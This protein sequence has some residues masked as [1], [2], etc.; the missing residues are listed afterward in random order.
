MI[1]F[2]LTAEITEKIFN[3]IMIFFASFASLR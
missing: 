1:E 3:E 2:L